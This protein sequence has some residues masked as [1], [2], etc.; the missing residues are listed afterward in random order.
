MNQWGWP[1]RWVTRHPGLPGTET[2]GLKPGESQ[3]YWDQLFTLNNPQMMLN[4]ILQPSASWHLQH[5][6][7]Y[8]IVSQSNCWNSTYNYAPVF[9]PLGS[10]WTRGWICRQLPTAIL[11][12]ILSPGIW[13]DTKIKLDGHSKHSKHFFF[14][15]ARLCLMKT[16]SFFFLATHKKHY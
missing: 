11:I 13:E 8:D 10:H 16:I 3:A 4:F 5:E 6:G 15:S 9:C 7:I 1:T 2:W 12:H 14:L